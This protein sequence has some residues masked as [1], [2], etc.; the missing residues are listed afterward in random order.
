MIPV[1]NFGN[2][3][4][5]STRLAKVFSDA[6]T[7]IAVARM[8]QAHL[9]NKN[10]I[11]ELALH[12]LD[13]SQSQNILDVGCG[14]GYFTAGLEG[15]LHRHARVLGIDM[16]PDYE[17]HYLK[18]CQRAKLQGNFM[19]DDVT[20][21]RS[22][23][24]KSY[25]LIASS[26]S[27]YFF[28]DQI[29][30]LSSLLKDDGVCIVIT[31]AVPHMHELTGFVRALLQEKGIRIVGDLPYE[32]LIRNFSSENGQELLDPWFADIRPITVKSSLVFPDGD[33]E[34]LRKY[35]MFK[36]PFF[37][38]AL[39]DQTND[40]IDSLLDNVKQEMKKTGQFTITK[41]DMIFICTQPKET[42]S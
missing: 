16:H 18:A 9:T 6:C 41:D 37:L 31:H 17:I 19:A 5:H 32:A 42:K 8:I 14:F 15:R 27:L 28:P 20:C 7:H 26:F 10:D 30:H 4:V 22:L 3:V 34:S 25:D 36:H 24:E 23:P 33:Y 35:F 21:I 38:P 40:M 11:R 2:G 12:S 1:L 13:L 29:G 39:G